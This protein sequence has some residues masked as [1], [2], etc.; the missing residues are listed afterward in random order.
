MF[1]K[2]DIGP[3]VVWSFR[4]AKTPITTGSG[5]DLQQQRKSAEPSSETKPSGVYGKSP[6]RFYRIWGSMG[7]I[8]YLSPDKVLVPGPF[9][10]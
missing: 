9:R 6:D 1:G 10:T 2:A 4:P 3:K 7:Q 8:M 5:S